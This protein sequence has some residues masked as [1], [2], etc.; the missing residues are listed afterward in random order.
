MLIGPLWLCHSVGL[1]L[2]PPQV[3]PG[4]VAKAKREN[5][6][7]S[8]LFF[9]FKSSIFNDSN[10]LSL[11]DVS[12][13]RLCCWRT[14]RWRAACWSAPTR[15]PRTR[16]TGSTFTSWA[17]SST[18]S[19]RTGSW[20]TATN[21]RWEKG[22][23]RSDA[24]L[25]VLKIYIYIYSNKIKG[26]RALSQIRNNSLEVRSF[27]GWKRGAAAGRW[28]RVQGQVDNPGLVCFRIYRYTWLER[29]KLS[30]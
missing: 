18:L 29:A 10:L 12:S 30:L 21:R 2:L 3:S 23:L 14:P 6:A 19:R 25:K 4:Q 20:R 28:L 22:R 7:F 15:G 17:S 26:S 5:N 1:F 24:C 11:S 8:F 16:S 13:L 9:F 27:T